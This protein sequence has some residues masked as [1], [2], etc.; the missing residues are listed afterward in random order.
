MVCE[1]DGPSRKNP[2][3]SEN[4][5]LSLFGLGRTRQVYKC[6]PSLIVFG[7]IQP[8]GSQNLPLPSRHAPFS[9]PGLIYVVEGTRSFLLPF[10]DSPVPSV[11]VFFYCWLSIVL[12]TSFTL[13]SHHLVQLL[14]IIP[15]IT[16]YCQLTSGTGY[17]TF[18]LARSVVCTI[19]CVA[20]AVRA[21]IANPFMQ[22]LSR[23]YSK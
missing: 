10:I 15:D 4:L 6:A 2:S 8:I 5:G 9:F 20:A 3:K 14:H 23:I 11:A 16:Q 7:S 19:Q 1:W 17:A 21:W 12:S 22:S 13:T 18:T